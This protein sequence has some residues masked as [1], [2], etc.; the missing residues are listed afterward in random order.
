MDIPV[1]RILFENDGTDLKRAIDIRKWL[2]KAA[3]MTTE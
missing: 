1:Y 3:D 2:A